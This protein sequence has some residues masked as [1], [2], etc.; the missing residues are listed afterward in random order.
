MAAAKKTSSKRQLRV[1]DEAVQK[2]T[3]KTW[4]QW[5]ALLDK[6]GARTMS[7][8][9]IVSHLHGKVGV[10][11]WWSQMVTVGYEQERGLR[12]EHERPDGFSISVSKTVAAGVDRLFEAFHE[13]KVCRRW[14]ED[15]AFTVRKA[16]PGKSLRITWIDGATSVEVNLYPKGDSKGQVSVQHSKLAD[17]AEAQ[18]MKAY[19][20]AALMRLKE[21]LEAG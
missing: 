19:W 7:H 15:S 6:A 14:L 16:T 11:A 5:F 12:V 3:G 18:R 21:H 13:R 8:K 1:G 9:E 17:A 2:A 4:A 10:P 20:S